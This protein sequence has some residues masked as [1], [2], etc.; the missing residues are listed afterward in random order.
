MGSDRKCFRLTD[1]PQPF[2]HAQPVVRSSHEVALCATLSNPHCETQ[3]R[4]VAGCAEMIETKE[5][6]VAAQI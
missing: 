6:L 5:T 3:I 4:M 2:D 1:K